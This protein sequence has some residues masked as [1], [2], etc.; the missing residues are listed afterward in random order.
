MTN[1]KIAGILKKKKQNI[2]KITN[3]LL[4]L[5][6]IKIKRIDGKEKFFS[7]VHSIKWFLLEKEVSKEKSKDLDKEIQKVLQEI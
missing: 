6:A 7:V 3:R 1:K 5:S 4:E 2:S